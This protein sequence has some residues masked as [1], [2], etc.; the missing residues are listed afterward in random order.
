MQEATEML[1]LASITY[2]TNCQLFTLNVGKLLFK[3]PDTYQYSQMPTQ[4]FH[5]DVLR[6]FHTKHVQNR[7]HAFL[8]W[9]SWESRLILLSAIS[10]IIMVTES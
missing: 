6:G 4:H 7:I 8:M 2:K 5:L 1:P 9:F 3:T 10:D